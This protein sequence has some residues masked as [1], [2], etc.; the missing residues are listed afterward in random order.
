MYQAKQAASYSII[1]PDKH[2]V[3]FMCY[4]L[5]GFEY[6]SISEA[7]SSLY[8]TFLGGEI[9]VLLSSILPLL[10][11]SVQCEEEPLHQQTV[12][13]QL[14]DADLSKRQIKTEAQTFVGRPIPLSRLLSDNCF[15][16]ALKAQI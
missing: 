12:W 5:Y 7:V 8:G 15:K 11:C 3:S 10:F 4:S 1:T 13:L 16:N 6:R 9:N 14:N 2:R